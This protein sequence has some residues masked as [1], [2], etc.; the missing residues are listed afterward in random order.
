M[1]KVV[2]TGG[3]GWIGKYVVH[4]LILPWNLK[5]EIM[6]ECSFIREWGGKFLVTVPEIEVIEP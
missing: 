6:K 3:S 2:V 1:K 4:S 5:D